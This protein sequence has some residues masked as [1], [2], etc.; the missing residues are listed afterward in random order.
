MAY[1]DRLASG[2]KSAAFL[3]PKVTQE[4]WDSIWKSDKDELK[5]SKP[6]PKSQR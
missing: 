5:V 4:K 3:P 6:Q 2:S 1:G